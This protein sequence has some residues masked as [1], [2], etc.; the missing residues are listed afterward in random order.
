M[1]TRELIYTLDIELK[2]KSDREW[3][4]DNLRRMMIE[5]ATFHVEKAIENTMR[6]ATASTTNHRYGMR[7]WETTDVHFN[8]NAY[9]LEN[10]K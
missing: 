8:R 3:F 6:T 10:I 2:R 7:S 5:F 1:T 4:E 9:P